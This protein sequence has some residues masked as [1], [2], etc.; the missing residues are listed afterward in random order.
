MKRSARI[1][2][3]LRIFYWVIIIGLSVGAYYFIQPYTTLLLNV[4]SGDIS[5]I[6]NA[7]NSLRELLQTSSS[8]LPR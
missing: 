5:N 8:S 7:S 4:A 1:S 6:Q 2:N 3:I